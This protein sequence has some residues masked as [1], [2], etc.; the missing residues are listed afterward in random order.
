MA[1]VKARPFASAA[2]AAGA[3]GASAFL[4][5]K[6]AQLSDQL[7]EL[8]DAV[9]ERF[10]SDDD[11]SNGMDSFSEAK[12]ERM[13]SGGRSKRPQSEIAEEAL[14]L[15]ETGRQGRAP[16][17]GSSQSKVGSIAY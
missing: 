12:S 10:S 11:Q 8:T 4:W 3:A 1:A 14:S 16:S 5:A 2:I 17:A 13:S 6:R 7:S 15:K 9:S